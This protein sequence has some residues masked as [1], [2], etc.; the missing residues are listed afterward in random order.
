[1]RTPEQLLNVVAACLH[2]DPALYCSTCRER[3]IVEMRFLGAFMLRTYFPAIT[4]QQISVLFGGRDHTTII[5]AL[6]R[7]GALIATGDVRFTSK[8][9]TVLRSMNLWLR[10][11]VLG[12]ASAISA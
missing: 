4:L 10:K 6:H 2:M 1:M 5:N 8:Y 7:A 9:Q 11:E 12:F 3:S